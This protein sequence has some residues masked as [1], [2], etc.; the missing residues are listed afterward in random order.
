MMINDERTLSGILEVKYQRICR[1][2][3]GISAAL[4]R[5]GR[6]RTCLESKAE[7]LEL[8]R[9][10]LFLW[11]TVT[12]R[13]YPAFWASQLTIAARISSQISNCSL[14]FLSDQATLIS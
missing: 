11:L 6:F 1:V 4:P 3:E 14:L 12:N 10:G 2:S 8:V 7:W 9:H 13:E 5:S